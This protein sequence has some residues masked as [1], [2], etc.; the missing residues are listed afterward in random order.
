MQEKY[1]SFLDELENALKTAST[2]LSAVAGKDNYQIDLMERAFLICEYDMFLEKYPTLFSIR[3]IN[4]SI[5]LLVELQDD[6]EP[7][8]DFESLTI[9]DKL[10]ILDE[11]EERI[12][13]LSRE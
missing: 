2:V 5:L 3:V 4:G 10:M 1:D 6:F 11:I 12:R 13:L 9:P 8:D 7:I